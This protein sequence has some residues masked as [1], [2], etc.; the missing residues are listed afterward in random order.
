MEVFDGVS[1]RWHN[2]GSI[3]KIYERMGFVWHIEMP[4]PGV[5]IFAPAALRCYS[6]HQISVQLTV[7]DCEALVGIEQHA[8]GHLGPPFPNPG[9]DQLMLDLSPGLHDIALFDATGRTVLQERTA[10]PKPMI[11]TAHLAPGLYHVRVDDDAAVRWV[12]Q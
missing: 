8:S 10:D 4:C 3:H 2:I 7:E 5:P 9:S 12:K 11:P 6:D 1:L